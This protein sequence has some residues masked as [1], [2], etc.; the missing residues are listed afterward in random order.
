[1][2]NKICAMTAKTRAIPSLPACG[3]QAGLHRYSLVAKVPGLC[4]DAASGN[5]TS[6]Y[7]RAVRV[8]KN[9]NFMLITNDL[10]T[11]PKP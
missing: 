9:H 11:S 10:M 4:P 5:T 7:C 3:S 8:S 2:L 1:M 6:P